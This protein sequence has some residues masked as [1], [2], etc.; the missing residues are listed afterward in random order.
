MYCSFVVRKI[1]FS[2]CLMVALQ[3]R[4]LDS[5][6]YWPFVLSKTSFFVTWWLHCP[7]GNLIPSCTAILCQARSHFVVALWLHSPQGYLT[8][9]C[10][11]LVFSKIS[12]WCTLMVA[13]PAR[14][15]GS[16]MNCS[17][18]SSKN[19][20]SMLLDDCIARKGIWHL[21]VWLLRGGQDLLLM[22]LDGCIVWKGI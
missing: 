17:F 9:S 6:M 1:S 8:P 3:A 12:F 15:L 7:Q 21:H 5:Y 4:V 13:S 11:A 10:S 14:V 22:L 19:F 16:L 20:L 18:M 2:W